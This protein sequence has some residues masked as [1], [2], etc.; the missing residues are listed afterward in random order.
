MVPRTALS[1]ALGLGLASSICMATAR[2]D[3]A[4]AP[5]GPP[6]TFRSGAVLVEV[7]VLARDQA[8][9]PVTDLTRA[10]ITVAEEGT[11]QEIVAF[12]RISVPLFHAS[13]GPAAAGPAR[14]VSSNETDAGARVFILVLDALHVA[15]NR[16]LDVRRYAK[17]F[18]EEYVGP[19]DLAAVI[20][21]GG[22]VSATEDFT[23]DKARLLAAVDNFTGTKLRSATVE[24]NEEKTRFYDGVAMHGGKDPSDD[25]R[26]N[27]ASSLT[28][29]LEAIAR[30][31]DRIEGRRKALLLFSE[32]IDYDTGDVTGDA[33]RH[34]SDVI[35][36]ME[37]ATGALMRSNVAMY[38]I[39]PRVL[40]TAQGDILETPIYEPSPGIAGGLSERGI[41]TEF[42]ASVRSLRDLAQATGGFLATDKGLS[43]GFDQIARETSDYYVLGYTPAKP[44]KPGE[45]RTLTVRTSRPGVTLT[46]RK[47]YTVLPPVQRQGLAASADDGMPAMGAP[48]RSRRSAPVTMTAPGTAASGATPGVPSELALLLASPLPKPGLPLRVQAIPFYGSEKKA[49]V[50]LVVEVMGGGL[51]FDEGGGRAH[52]RIELALLTIDDKGKAANGRS[53]T[54]ELSLPPEELARV[55]TTG[56]RWLSKLDLPPGRY[57][58]RVAAT[59]VGT[60]TSGLVTH[61]IQVPD[62]VRQKLSLSGVT[63]TSLPS[64]LMST[65]GKGWMETSLGTPPSAA[66]TFVAGDRV[67]AAV[68]VYAP[69]PGGG[70]AEVLASVEGPG[71]TTI[72]LTGASRNGDAPGSRDVTFQLDTAAVPKGHYVLRI[73]GTRPGTSAP[74]ERQVP[75]DVI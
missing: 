69:G 10:D 22:A 45:T 56:V 12:E 19:S 75:F 51:R 39:D 8:G 24:R 33:Q 74:V 57:Q 28:N 73:V 68:E 5:A 50:Q 63:L 47:G 2:A 14:D 9:R 23:S 21:P 60:G 55:R 25:E 4:G 6:Q 36:A 29:T 20:S 38:T 71:S 13:A 54:I 61:M 34:A 65:R 64:V 42:N 44:A 48:P 7:A 1:L 40:G 30:H 49:A 43:R 32:G 11:P 26:A 66:R 17:Q 35:R 37:R 59:A 3:Q 70:D 72:R 58:V 62:F 15:P 52:E 53:T 27:R 18:I 46:A 31:A 67:T 41:Q 16:N